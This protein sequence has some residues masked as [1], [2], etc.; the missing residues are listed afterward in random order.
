MTKSRSRQRRRKVVHG[1][2]RYDPK[3]DRRKSGFGDK[4]LLLLAHDLAERVELLQVEGEP[5]EPASLRLVGRSGICQCLRPQ[6]EVHG[7]GK[8]PRHSEGI[9]HRVARRT[10]TSRTSPT[11]LN[12]SISPLVKRKPNSFSTAI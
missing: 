8:Q 6:L 10:M 3:L 2:R 1:V 7:S 4:K 9:V 5:S 11:V 12:P